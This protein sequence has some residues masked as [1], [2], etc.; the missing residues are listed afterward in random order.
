MSNGLSDHEAQLFIAHLPEN[1]TIK[2]ELLMKRKVND[3]NITEFKIKL[4]YENW[5]SVF[6][7][8]IKPALIIF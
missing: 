5:E 2:K 6:N 7:N 1:C 3:N 8:D 4:S